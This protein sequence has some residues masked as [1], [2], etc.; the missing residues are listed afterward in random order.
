LAKNN[1]KPRQ[2]KKAKEYTKDDLAAAIERFQRG[3]M[4]SY[5]AHKQYSIP[6][7]TVENHIQ[8]QAK[9]EKLENQQ[10]E[11]ELKAIRKI[12]KSIQQCYLCEKSLLKDNQHKTKWIACFN[13]SVWCC[14]K[15]LPDFFK[16]AS[17]ANVYKCNNCL[18]LN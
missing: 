6:R 4:S 2:A 1:N 18:S 10:K 5:S 8:K 3:E 11:Q 14:Y 17:A 7:S 16:G 12:N 15:C 13:C 9:L